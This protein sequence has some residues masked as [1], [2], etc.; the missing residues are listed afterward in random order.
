MKA[1]YLTGS[2]ILTVLILILAFGNIGAQCSNAN[3]LWIPLQQANPTFI[4]LAVAV[5]GILTG[6]LY[7]GFLSRVFSSSPEEEDED[8]E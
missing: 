8:F 1:L 2:I 4:V 7:A 5:V 6:M 3:F